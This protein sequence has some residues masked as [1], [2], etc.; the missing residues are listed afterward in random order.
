MSIKLY[1]KI[2]YFE[3]VQ[4]EIQLSLKNTCFWY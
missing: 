3:F 4:N 2:G 1:L